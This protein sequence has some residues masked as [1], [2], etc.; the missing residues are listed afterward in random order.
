M[1]IECPDCGSHFIRRRHGRCRSCRVRIVIHVGEI[2]T[3]LDRAWLRQ[4]DGRME[5]VS[6]GR[7]N[8]RSLL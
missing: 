7:D 1:E 6:T 2:F 5:L 8:E 3:S 4:P